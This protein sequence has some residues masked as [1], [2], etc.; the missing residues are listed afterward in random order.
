[1]E[2]FK[3]NDYSTHGHFRAEI[4]I[5]SFALFVVGLFVFPKVK[6]V[7]L[8]IKLNS[9]VDSVNSY[10]ESIN[11]F[12][13]SRLLYDNSFKLDGVYNISNGSLVYNDDVYNIMVYGNIPSDG[14]LY[15]QDNVLKDGCVTVGKYSVKVLD[16]EVESATIGSC[17]NTDIALGI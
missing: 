1:M 9:A 15:Y 13:V 17:D 16:G 2:K 11:S 4:F 14:Y 5:I 12:Y 10:K 8:D 6:G 7:I 3:V